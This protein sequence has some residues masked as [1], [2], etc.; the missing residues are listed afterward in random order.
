MRS[1]ARQRRIIL[2]NLMA[3]VGVLKCALTSINPEESREIVDLSIKLIDLLSLGDNLFIL[4]K[5]MTFLKEQTY[6]FSFFKMVEQKI[7]NA[8]QEIIKLGE[9]GS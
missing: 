9:F 6:G 7:I 5:L 8:T 2:Q 3:S 1:V 4:E